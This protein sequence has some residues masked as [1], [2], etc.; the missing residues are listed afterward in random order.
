MAD[1]IRDPSIPPHTDVTYP[2]IHFEFLPK[3]KPTAKTT[4]WSCRNT[5][6]GTEMGQVRWYGPWRQY[7]FFPVP[8]TVYSEGCLSDITDFLEQLKTARRKTSGALDYNRAI[9]P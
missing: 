6:S 1:T 7:C 5:S 2:Y 4:A 8:N 9:S 3:K